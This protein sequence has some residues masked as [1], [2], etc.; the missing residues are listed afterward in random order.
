MIETWNLT[1][2]K[3]ELDN[4]VFEKLCN[5]LDRVERSTLHF[6][7]LS[8]D[9]YQSMKVFCAGVGL[10]LPVAP[11]EEVP[12]GIR[13]GLNLN[14]SETEF[15][16]ARYLEL[17]R[18][19]FLAYPK[20]TKDGIGPLKRDREF[21]KQ[22]KLQIGS[23]GEGRIGV[24]GE[25]K[26]KLSEQ[27]LLGVEFELMEIDGGWKT[28]GEKIY[29]LLMPIELP[30]M[31]SVSCD[32]QGNQ[33]LPGQK[34]AS[35]DGL[36]ILDGLVSDSRIAFNFDEFPDFDIAVTQEKFGPIVENSPPKRICSNRFFTIASE[37][38]PTLEWKMVLSS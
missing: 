25:A 10:I 14:Y 15:A 36:Y 27:Q 37:I 8:N 22:K 32:N 17:A 30:P 24:R 28:E 4:I 5:H 13:V 9:D 33:F 34:P 6:P 21:N 20:A 3:A 26:R 29:E 38:C 2:R 35:T 18:G 12:E 1:F 19:E 7:C 31:A 16:E 23:V 11:E